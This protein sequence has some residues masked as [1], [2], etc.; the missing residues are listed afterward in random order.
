M[1]FGSLAPGKFGAARRAINLFHDKSCWEELIRNNMALDFSWDSVV[2]QY[3]E[4][5]R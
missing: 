1:V 5:Y 4:L 3:L 2:P